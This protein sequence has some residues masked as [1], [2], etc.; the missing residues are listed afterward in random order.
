[1][2]V[3]YLKKKGLLDHSD[4]WTLFEI[5]NIH[6]VERPIREWEIVLDI[7][8]VWDMDAS[9]ALLV[10]KYSYH[11][12][13]TTE[14]VLHRKIP[15]MHGWVSIEYKKGKWQK[16]YCFVRENA[17]YHSK[18]NK[19]SFSFVTQVPNT[20]RFDR[21]PMLQFYVISLVMTCIHYFNL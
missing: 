21:A 14:S 16:R 6:S 4:D 7:L 1:M 19:V 15:P 10:K 3:Q 5:D 20:D 18:D 9:N 8:N 12:T 13:L 2:V 17:I 11:Y